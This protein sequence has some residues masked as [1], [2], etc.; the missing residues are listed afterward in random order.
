MFIARQPIFKRDLD[1]YGYE[2]LYRSSQHAA[3]YDGT[4][5]NLSTTAVLQGL[6]ETGVGKISDYSRVFVN[7]TRDMLLSD[8]LEVIPPEHMVIEILEGT[9]LDDT[10]I[11]RVQELK[12][13][14]YK[15]ALDDFDSDLSK[16]ELM[17]DSDII[18]F[19]IRS[20]PLDAITTQVAEAHFRKKTI[21][22]EKVETLEEFEH[23]KQMGFHLFQGYFF[24]RPNII[25]RATYKRQYK[26]TYLRVLQELKTP[27]PS[28]QKLT[29]I[30]E[31]DASLSYRLMKII[32]HSNKDQ[33]SFSIKRALV[34]MGIR[35]FERW[36]N[37]LMLQDLAEDK[38][39]E[40]LKISLVRSKFAEQLCGAS[41]LQERKIDA[42]VMALFSTIDAI[43]DDH[44]ETVL[45]SVPLSTEIKAALINGDSL[46]APIYHAVLCYEKGDWACVE[47]WAGELN[48]DTAILHDMYVRAVEWANE[49]YQ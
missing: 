49:V 12:K 29:E 24:S 25:T 19:D 37:I 13:M 15:I 41:H 20:T 44:M 6:L 14:G 47:K 7:F 17:N 48:I 30:I 45:A 40:L 27:E 10:L 9:I 1:T 31:T 18:K 26:H 11:Q 21:L 22:A 5:A 23:A 34:Q 8:F 36:I 39:D 3:G 16:Y 42:A 46:L 38:P 32:S 35:N 2:L 4:D 43:L 33:L 28:Y